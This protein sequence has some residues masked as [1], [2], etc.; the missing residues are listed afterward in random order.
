MVPD[1]DLVSGAVEGTKRPSTSGRPDPETSMKNVLGGSS[2]DS[3]MI[4]FLKKL[5]DHKLRQ[6]YQHMCSFM[7]FR[8]APG[9]RLVL[10]HQS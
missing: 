10:Y 9:F 8:L 5:P 7:E 3:I 2:L 1:S 6:H 4:Y